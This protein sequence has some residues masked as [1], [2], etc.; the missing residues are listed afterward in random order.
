MRRST[1]PSAPPSRTVRRA[2]R[3]A[4]T[5][6]TAC[7]APT[8]WMSR[9]RMIG[10]ASANCVPVALAPAGSA[11]ERDDRAAHD[12]EGRDSATRPRIAMARFNL[13]G[14]TL[15]PRDCPR[16]ASRSWPPSSGDAPTALITFRYGRGQT[17]PLGSWGVHA[18]AHCS[19]AGNAATPGTNVPTAI[20]G[21]GRYPR[22]CRAALHY[23]RWHRRRDTAPSSS[24]RPLHR[25]P[26]RGPPVPVHYFARDAP[27]CTVAIWKGG[28]I[29]P[30]QPAYDNQ[31][32]DWCAHS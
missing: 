23:E 32:S 10:R 11:Q 1:A 29:N 13:P 14:P 25:S 16:R 12:D 4:S 31:A 28:V 15:Q 18:C 5:S 6:S 3:R 26:S 21:S 8:K 24:V 22:A 9:A 30:A 19:T 27:P 2:W 17:A 20:H 7:C